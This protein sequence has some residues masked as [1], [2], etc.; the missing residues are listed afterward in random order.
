[1]FLV[2][3]SSGKLPKCFID[4]I[5]KAP[6]STEMQ[7]SWLDCSNWRDVEPD[8]LGE[9]RQAGGYDTTKG[10][11]LDESWHD[12][13]AEKSHSC[14]WEWISL[15]PSMMWSAEVHFPQLSP[16]LVPPAQTSAA[17]EPVSVSQPLLLLLHLPQ[18]Y[19]WDLT[20][21]DVTDLWYHCELRIFV[22]ER[23]GGPQ[24]ILSVSW[25]HRMVEAAGESFVKN[26]GKCG[27]WWGKK[28]WGPALVSWGNCCSLVTV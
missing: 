21:C 20:S 1:M 4:C 5:T 18:H 10:K 3:L 8:W 6:V 25:W 9:G 24:P 11:F 26:P 16:G 23:L 2:H 13:V 7:S 19:S 27:L 22:G 17:L 15:H 14:N 12:G 28:S